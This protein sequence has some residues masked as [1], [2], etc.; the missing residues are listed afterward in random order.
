MNKRDFLKTAGIAVAATAVDAPAVIAQSK[1]PIRWRLQTYAGASLATH[2]VKPAVDSFNKIANGEMA[3]ELYTADQLV[4]TPDLFNA[5]QKGTL[6][7]VQS[8]DDSMASPADVAVFGG[9]FPFA[10]R[11]S[12]DVPVLFNEYGLKDIWE[13]AYGEIDG[14]TWLSAGSWDPC[15]FN[16]VEPIRSL[17]DLEGL[18]V[19]TFPTAGKFLSRFGV[20]PVTLPWDEVK[21]AVQNG[22]LDGLAWSGI[23]E[24]YTVGWADVTKYFL[25][26][27]ISGAWCGSFFANADSWN[28]LPE[29]LRE[30]FRV[31]MDS[32]HYY[33]QH[34]YWGGEAR[35]RV[36][37]TKLELTSIPDEQWKQVEAEAL[38]FWDEI[39]QTSP[40]A[41]RVIEIFKAYNA[42]MARAGR[43]YR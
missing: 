42:T 24:A 30:L 5:L 20:I 29:H 25:T 8:D 41:A 4:P 34:W 17:D 19:F 1:S 21:D 22:A 43:P 6:D 37:G 27:N 26:N 39:G 15:H 16:T 10:T 32:S 38:K 14:V 31:C 12:L 40:R 28:A 7:A 3:I 35:Q 9:Y 18:R 11:H 36:R 33:R 13:E 23:T 2:V